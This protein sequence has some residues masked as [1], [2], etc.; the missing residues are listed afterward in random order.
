MA[1][2]FKRLTSDDI[3]TTKTRLHEVIPLTGSIVSGTYNAGGL[4][5][6]VVLGNEYNIKTYGHG[7]FQS[8][9]DYPYLELPEN[10]VD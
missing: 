2:T 1:T 5:S 9:F 3:S 8:V 7:M 10:F 6:A 4:A